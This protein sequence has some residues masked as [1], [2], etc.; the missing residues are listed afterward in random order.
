MSLLGEKEQVI[1]SEQFQRLENPVRMIH[2]T[3]GL[4][5]DTCPETQ[6]L[7]ED[8][9]SLSDK[10]TLEVH[11]FAIE[12]ELAAQFQVARV[13][14]TV[15]QTEKDFGIRL[16]GLPSGYEFASLLHAILAVSRSAT[17]LSEESKTL[18]RSVTTPTH[19]QVFVT[20]T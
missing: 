2:F 18:L 17:E 7:L 20:P 19:I 3:Q 12:Q 6:R 14:A 8:L 16:Y 10:V 11:N 1:V 9:A 5:C 4:M 13:P 15:I